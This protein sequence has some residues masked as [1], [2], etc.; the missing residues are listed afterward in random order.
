MSAGAGSERV[1]IGQRVVALRRRVAG[2]GVDGYGRLLDLTARPRTAVRP[3]TDVVTPLA[4]TSFVLAMAALV[5]ARFL[6]WTELTAAAWLVIAL[7]LIAVV[8]VLGR[9]RLGAALDLGRD[10][11]VVGERA[12]GRIRLVNESRLRTPPLTVEL[13][14]GSTR[15]AFDLPGL[16][17]GAEHEELYAIPTTRR[18]VLTVGP[19]RTVRGDPFGLLRRE[20]L[21]TDSDLLYVHPRTVR[22]EGSASGMV[23]DLEGETV[24]KLSDNDVAFHALRGYVPGDDLRF[25][26]WRSTARTGSLMVR[27]FEETRRSH[28]LVALSTRLDDFASDEEFEAAVSIAGSLGVQTLAEGHTLT[29]TTSTRT[30]AAASPIRLLDQ[31]A[32]VDYERQAPPLSEVARRLAD[33][34]ASVAVIVC[35]SIVDAAEIRRARRFLPID[36]RTVVMRAQPDA[37]TKVRAMGDLD[38]ATLGGLD[39]L[40]STVRRIAR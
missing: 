16:A 23:R 31:L 28:M 20:Q 6:A 21:L 29:A 12:N 40:P 5:S 13:A 22:I 34:G 17:A 15:V 39:D 37:E 19:V 14:V 7:L 11:V 24:R 38:V 1:P 26:H 3:V 35:G 30:L 2:W 18:A 4:W 8:F 36:V 27:Q 9:S 10:R 33:T 25:V 32:G